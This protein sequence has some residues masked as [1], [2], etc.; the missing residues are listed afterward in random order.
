MDI[1][2]AAFITLTCFKQLPLYANMC[3]ESLQSILNEESNEQDK[4]QSYTPDLV[5]Q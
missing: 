4:T 5:G 2:T 3:A 1:L